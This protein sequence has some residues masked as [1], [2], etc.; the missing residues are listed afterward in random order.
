MSKFWDIF[1]YEETYQSST[2]RDKAYYE[3]TF[4]RNFHSYKKGDKVEIIK[5]DYEDF[6]LDIEDN[7]YLPKWD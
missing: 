5:I 1:E 4:L 2:T 7:L 3:C 6:S